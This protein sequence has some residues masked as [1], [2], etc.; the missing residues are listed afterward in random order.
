M[1]TA[2]RVN[3]LSV[4]VGGKRILEGLTLEVPHGEQVWAWP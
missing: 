1:K 4:S 2:L 3:D